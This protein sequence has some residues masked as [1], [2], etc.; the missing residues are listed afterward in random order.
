MIGG[1]HIAGGIVT[2]R[3][4][5][6]CALVCLLVA[7][8][9]VRASAQRQDRD[10]A[11]AHVAPKDLPLTPAQRQRYI[12]TYATELPGGEKVT[13]RILEENGSLRLWASAPDESRRLYYQGDDVF[14]MENA[15]GF[16]IAFAVLQDVAMKFTVR[17][18][19]GELVA[20]R[21]K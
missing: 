15:P 4:G 9:P 1:A 5:L 17:K 13:L 14:L 11:A 21:V 18:P 12:G 10:T 2:A 6:P 16:V 20:I 8:L 3:F 19:E 7:G